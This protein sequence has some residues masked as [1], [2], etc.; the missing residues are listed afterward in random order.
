MVTKIT[1]VADKP[2]TIGK[3]VD[4]LLKN[5]FANESTPEAF[6]CFRS[7]YIWDFVDAMAEEEE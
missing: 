4:W 2:I 7:G 6:V 1:D 3:A 5:G